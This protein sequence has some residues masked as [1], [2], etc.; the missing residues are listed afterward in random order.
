MG[1]LLGRFFAV[2]DF[3]RLGAGLIPAGEEGSGLLLFLLALLVVTLWRGRLWCSHVCPFG[4]LA[5]LAGWACRAKP[6]TPRR[7]RGLARALPWVTVAAVAGCIAWTGRTA[8]AG[9]EPFGVCA[10]LLANPRAVTGLW[11]GARGPLLLF[12]LLVLLSLVSL[13]FYCR[14]LCG[15][16]ALLRTVARARPSAVPGDAEDHSGGRAEA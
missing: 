9:T 14:N 6:R 1:A 5:E 4:S 7:L 11:S 10:Q 2:A 8:A 13:R 12:A 3:A 16:G 15:A